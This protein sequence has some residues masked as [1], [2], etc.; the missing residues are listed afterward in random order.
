VDATAIAHE[1][2]ETAMRRQ[3]VRAALDQ[4][5]PRESKKPLP[6][7]K[8]LSGYIAVACFTLACNTA[9]L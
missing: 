8:S 6:R 4:L 1:Q 5:E 9:R 2:V 3:V 7:N